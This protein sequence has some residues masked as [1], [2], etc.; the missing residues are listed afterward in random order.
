MVGRIVFALFICMMLVVSA[1][2]VENK[3][4]ERIMIAAGSRGVVPFP[5]HSHQNVLGDCQICHAL[6][7]QEPGGIARLKKEGR[8]VKKQVMNKLCV[9]CHKLQEKMGNPS[10]PKTCSKCHIKKKK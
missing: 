2:A 10:G 1:I 4:A 7:P 3:G 6:F 8:L 5:H 9:N